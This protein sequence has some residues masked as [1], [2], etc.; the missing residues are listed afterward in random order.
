MGALP[1]ACILA[2]SSSNGAVPFL[3]SQHA[4]RVQFPSHICKTQVQRQVRT[5]K[6][7]E[8]SDFFFGLGLSWDIL[9]VNKRL[10][11]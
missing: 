10:A 5:L 6:V 11:W 4:L 2:H 1:A 3:Q 7:F 8:E 9:V